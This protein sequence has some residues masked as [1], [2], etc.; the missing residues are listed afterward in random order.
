MIAKLPDEI[1]LEIFDLY[2][3]SF[4]RQHN[5][6]RDWNNRNGW[7][8][9]AHVC[10]NWRCI[11]L[12]S[13]TRL[14]LR[15]FFTD[16][17][18]TRAAVLAGLPPL[19]II[20]A[21]HDVSVAW[22]V[23][24]L[25]SENRLISALRYPDRVCKIALKI[26]YSNR[27]TITKALDCAF[28]SLEALE[29]HNTGVPAF[30]LPPTFLMTTAKSLRRLKLPGASLT[31]LTTLLSA[32]T[33]LVDLTLGINTVFSPPQGVLFPSL[34]DLFQPSPPQSVSLSS[35][36]QNLT[37]LRHL[38]VSVQSFHSS[39]TRSISPVKT[40][41]V[42]S[43][44]ELNH[45][46]FQGH[47]TEVEELVAGLATPS[48]QTLHVTLNCGNSAFKIPHLSVII[49]NM[50]MIFHT[51]Q[52]RVSTT[53]SIISLLPHSD[54]IDDSPLNILVHGQSAI[55]QICSEISA[56]LETVEDLFVTLFTS[57]F[58]D[59]GPVNIAPFRG[60]FEQLPNVKIL[61]VQHGLETEVANLLRE[62]NGQPTMN[63]HVP[64]PDGVDLDATISSDLP[65][66]P[67][68]IIGINVGIFPSLEGIEVHRR[69]PGTQIPES[70][71]ASDLEPFEELV[72]A[73]QQAGRSVKVYC[74]TDQA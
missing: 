6:E 18:P 5:Y 2:R 22:T 8:K 63:H 23:G 29:L 66:N 61:R 10:H 39:H 35:L 51:A 71:H 25:G 34:Q 70:E 1:L 38:D 55:A 47:T 44:A 27:N 3:R 73:W 72:T 37:R 20:V 17:T 74:K 50:G 68:R 54:F 45:F 30:S 41:G 28:P 42:V 46:R 4:E 19:P 14:Q 40:T 64:V 15:L 53:T 7:F 31:S 33:A 11:V 52:I 60:F 58:P 69:S 56:M 26:T 13:S 43:L 36:L 16:R 12:A 62:Y 49:R 65:I 48:L 9:L 32:T 59:L 24:R 67:S 21:Y 57:V